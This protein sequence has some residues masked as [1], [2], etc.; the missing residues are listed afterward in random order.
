MAKLSSKR[1]PTALLASPSSAAASAQGRYLTIENLTNP[2]A[3]GEVKHE[4]NETKAASKKRSTRS[5]LP[6]T[7]DSDRRAKQR[8]IVKRCY[9][10]K[11]VRRVVS[12]TW[13]C[14]RPWS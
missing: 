7:T 2:E 4:P 13:S 3:M 8:M 14:T 9:Y 5:L 11:I 12:T 10:K 6:A 1:S